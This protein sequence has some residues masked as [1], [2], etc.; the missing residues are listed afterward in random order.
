M[1]KIISIIFIL[2]LTG[3]WNYNEINDLAITTA[4]A[5]DKEMDKYKVSVLI[6]NQKK[7]EAPSNNNSNFV[8]YSGLGKT[9]SEAI[10]EIDLISSKKIYIEHLSVLIISEDIAKEGINDILDFFLRDSSSTKRFEV[11][12]A[13]NTKALNIIKTITPLESFPSQGIKNNIKI[14]SETVSKSKSVIYNDFI[15]DIMSKG[16][17]PTLPSIIKTKKHLKLDN[18]AVFK[19]GKL[20]NFLSINNSKGVNIINN[21]VSEMN[22]YLKCG[23]NYSTVKI[24]NL[25]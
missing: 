5:I 15:Y 4:I 8:I 22:L 2:I 24:F 17:N 7:E 9:I 12:I 23:K 16:K 20:V 10:N 18:L 13:K 11:V 19:N 6:T 3:C 1:K 25:I 14:A 21:N